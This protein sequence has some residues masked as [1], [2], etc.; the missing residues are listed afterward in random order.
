M[1]S[2]TPLPSSFDGDPDF[3]EESW[4]KKLG[5]RLKEEPLVP[6]GIL[7]T[8]GALVGASR[9]MRNNVSPN[10]ASHHRAVSLLLRSSPH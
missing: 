6:L 7:L 9:A 4:L 1:S 8:C 2:D 5:R 3:F 10:R